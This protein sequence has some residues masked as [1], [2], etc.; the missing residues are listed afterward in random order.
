MRHDATGARGAPGCVLV[1]HAAR[2]IAIAPSDAAT[3]S[4]E[5]ASLE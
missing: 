5:M 2:P 3:R 1:A 4:G